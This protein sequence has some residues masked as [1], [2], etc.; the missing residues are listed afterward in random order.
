VGDFHSFVKGFV[1]RGDFEG[2]C[3]SLAGFCLG[4]HLS[5]VIIVRNSLFVFVA[6]NFHWEEFAIFV[7]FAHVFDEFGA[8]GFIFFGFVLLVQYTVAFVV[9]SDAAE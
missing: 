8:E 6:R 2:G 7:C 9:E 5:G 4:G 3:A 1:F